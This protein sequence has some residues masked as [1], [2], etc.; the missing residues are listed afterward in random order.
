MAKNCLSKYVRD[1]DSNVIL[2]TSLFW[3]LLYT[4]KGNSWILGVMKFDND[5]ILSSAYSW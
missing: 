4:K 2:N 1:V 5:D 3:S